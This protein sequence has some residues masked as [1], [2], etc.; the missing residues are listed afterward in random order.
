[1]PPRGKM[2]RQ[3][4]AKHSVFER[5]E[6][7]VHHP[8]AENAAQNPDDHERDADLNSFLKFRFVIDGN[9][10]R[11]QSE[12]G[13]TVLKRRIA[14]IERRVNSSRQNKNDVDARPEN[15]LR[16]FLPYLQMPVPRPAIVSAVADAAPFSAPAVN[17]RFRRVVI[18]NNHFAAFWRES[19]WVALQIFW[20][21]R[22]KPLLFFVD[23]KA[24][25]FVCGLGCPFAI[26]SSSVRYNRLFVSKT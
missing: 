2:R 7:L 18:Q 21:C 8:A 15:D 19:D 9:E 5:L 4:A 6:Q 24:R 17:R 20:L 10:R 13:K 23:T 22:C 16:L 11:N 3:S 14:Q 1:M 12:R 25:M 26:F